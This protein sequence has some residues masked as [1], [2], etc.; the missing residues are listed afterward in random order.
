MSS[1]FTAWF[2]VYPEGHELAG[3]TV[4]VV[5]RALLHEMTARLTDQ[6]SA[7]ALEEIRE[8]AAQMIERAAGEISDD[9]LAADLRSMFL[10]LMERA[11]R[12]GVS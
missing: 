1:S 6:S 3:Q 7:E 4:E 10:D 11:T 9:A 8:R 2:T 12:G 5:P